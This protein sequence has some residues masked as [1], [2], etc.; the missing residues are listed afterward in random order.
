MEK[1]SKRHNITHVRAKHLSS[2]QAGAAASTAS[3]IWFW[4]GSGEIAQS[5]QRQP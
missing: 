4:N 2:R 3:A 1:I 5:G